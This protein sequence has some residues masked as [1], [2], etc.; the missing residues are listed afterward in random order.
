MLGAIVL[1][2]GAGTVLIGIQQPAT[3]TVLRPQTK[4]VAQNQELVSQYFHCEYPAHYD[5]QPSPTNVAALQAWVLL[6]H[7]QG[8]HYEQTSRLGLTIESL[9]AGGVTETSG[10]KLYQ[11]RPELYQLTT[12]TAGGDPI[13]VAKRQDPTYQQTVLWPHGSYLLT[14][15]LTAGGETSAVDADL[16]TILSS[17]QW[18]P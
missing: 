12:A 15:S 6:A 13:I 9:P 11:S 14:I 5:L 7:Q 17:L 3:G 1:A 8:T 18:Q 10:Y 4:P 16:Q 2:A